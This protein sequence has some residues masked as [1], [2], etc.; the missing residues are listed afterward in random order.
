MVENIKKLAGG[1]EPLPAPPSQG[2]YCDL[3]STPFCRGE[4]P[5]DNTFIALT[6]PSQHIC[7]EMLVQ[8]TQSCTKSQ[9]NASRAWPILFLYVTS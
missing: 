9:R 6:L 3:G 8:G 1:I 5:V 7:K 2:G 4:Y